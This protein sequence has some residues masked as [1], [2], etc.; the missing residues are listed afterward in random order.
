MKE[1]KLCMM[2][3]EVTKSYDE[4]R[5]QVRLRLRLHPEILLKLPFFHSTRKTQI[6]EGHLPLLTHK[7][8]A[9]KHKLYVEAPCKYVYLYVVREA[10]FPPCN[11][12][13]HFV[14]LIQFTRCVSHSSYTACIQSFSI[15]KLVI[16]SQRYFKSHRNALG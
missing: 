1:L 8:I 16:R 12:D 15:I 2:A 5:F 13:R 9:I 6:F 4:A 14:R 10:S 3:G 7:I 11:C